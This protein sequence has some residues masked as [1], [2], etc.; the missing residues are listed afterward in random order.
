[1]AGTYLRAPGRDRTGPTDGEPCKRALL[2]LNLGMEGAEL[3]IA[4]TK[5]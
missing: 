4:T 3:T 1:M 2:G 5:V